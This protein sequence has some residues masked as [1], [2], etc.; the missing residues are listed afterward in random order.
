M[1]YTM[2]PLG[3]PEGSFE[4]IEEG[5]RLA[6]DLG[7]HKARAYFQTH[8]GVYYLMSGGDPKK[9]REYIESGLEGA[10]LTGEIELIVPTTYEVSTS[11]IIV[12]NFSRV[13]QLAPKLIALIEKTHTEHE[14]FGRPAN[15][16][17]QLH[18]YYGVSLGA[19]GT[20]PEGKRWLEKGLSFAADINNLIS[21]AYVE[22]WY[23]VFYMFKGDWENVM[24]HGRSSVDHLEKSQM[25]I[26]VGPV[27]AWLGGGYLY[28]GQ[29]DKAL[30]CAEKGLKMH[31]DLNLPF[32]L[33]SIHSILSE[34][35]L[36][37][38][39]LEKALLHAKQAVEF[40]RTNKETY[41]EAEANISLGRVIAA[42]G[43]K[44][45]EEGREYLL[46]GMNIFDKL[47]VKPRYAVGLLYLG[48]L[49]ADAGQREAA[50]E[51]L[52]KAEE[53]FQE[54][55]MDYWLG[56]AQEALTAL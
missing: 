49:H 45:F 16:Y 39:N 13:C 27:W 46:Q 47:Q 38:K 32:L 54:M 3:Y 18:G 34:I 52:K 31:T 24:K 20:F 42:T 2:R 41:F 19:M 25:R 33:G 51:N 44:K 50:I 29:T 36:E 6:R 35:H 1:A 11:Q 48:K 53:M 26:L 15:I 9:G 40:S 5:E 37:L 7:N 8:M 55:G 23:G 12:G 56:K 4:F 10:E 30:Q 21:I 43:R 22:M 14:Q 28:S 17:S